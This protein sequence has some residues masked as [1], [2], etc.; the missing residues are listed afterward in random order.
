MINV[1]QGTTVTR[2]KFVSQDQWNKITY[3]TETV[4]VRFVKETRTILNFAG[5]EVLSAG[6]ILTNTEWNHNDRI[7]YDREYTIARIERKHHFSDVFWK[8]FLT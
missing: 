2:K 7:V 1:Y 6:Y 5:E 4:A 8:V 3:S